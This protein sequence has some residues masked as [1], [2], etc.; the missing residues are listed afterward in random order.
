[1]RINQCL[2]WRAF[3]VGLVV[4]SLFVGLASAWSDG[5]VSGSWVDGSFNSLS[6]SGDNSGWLNST[7][8]A[9]NV[10]ADGQ[11]YEQVLTV[12]YIEGTI[13]DVWEISAVKRFYFAIDFEST[14][15]GSDVFALFYLAHEM[16]V[17]VNTS[18]CLVGNN[19][20]D[21]SSV[22]IGDYPN[23][24]VND[25]VYYVR[26]IRASATV[27]TVSYR[28]ALVNDVF[29]FDP[30]DTSLAYSENFTVSEDFWD[31][32]DAYLYVGHEGKG[33]FSVEFSDLTYMSSA[34]AFTNPV[35]VFGDFWSFL[36]GIVGFF[37]SFF[38]MAVNLAVGLIP[39]VPVF[40][41]AYLLDAVVASI[42][43]GGV[44][45]IGYFFRAVW[46]LVYNAGS[47]IVGVLQSIADAIP[48]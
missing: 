35:G 26:L 37:S 11:G 36:S 45:P 41:L 27:A 43:E 25:A 42:A 5:G 23:V 21:A 24:G 48:L 34:S 7:G 16:G 4:L 20:F 14:S 39:L 28:T 1:M 15:A 44:Q 18:Q 6:A 38:A 9:L 8:V 22:G 3:A 40:F 32:V 47:M 19:Q 46:D 2:V 31:D 30:V 29:G 10:L 33:D 17:F 12:H 13:T